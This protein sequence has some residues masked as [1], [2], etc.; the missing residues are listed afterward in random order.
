MYSSTLSLTSALDGGGWPTPRPGGLPPG[1]SRYPLYRRL[2]GPQGRSGRVRKIFATTGIPSPEHPALSESP[3]QL[4]YR[5]PWKWNIFGFI[6]APTLKEERDRIWKRSVI[7]ILFQKFNVSDWEFIVASC[8]I[9]TVRLWISN[10][11]NNYFH[12]C[13][14]YDSYIILDCVEAVVGWLLNGVL[15]R[16]WKESVVA[17]LKCSPRREWGK[18]WQ[19]VL[20]G[21]PAQIQKG[22]ARMHVIC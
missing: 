16:I 21:V 1:K 7:F 17:S 3:Y 6:S 22:T 4:S 19:F 12:L 20:A 15:E 5:G 11:F 14:F 9:L 13:S 18:P 8:V 10:T 2:G